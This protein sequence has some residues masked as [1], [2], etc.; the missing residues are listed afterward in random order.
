VFKEDPQTDS[1]P[2]TEEKV[3]RWIF[4]TF[5][6]RGVYISLGVSLG[7]LLLYMA[8]SM[9]D[10][11]FP[12]SVLFLLLRILRYTSLISCAFSLFALGR[13]VRRLVYRPGLRSI[14][15]LVVYFFASLLS[16][17]LAMLDSLVVAA[18]GGNV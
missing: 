18:T 7:I 15:A 8:S 4:S 1:K 16:A 11:G 5:M 17:S 9:P 3:R 6:R 14:L 2:K 13:S 12:D 10:P